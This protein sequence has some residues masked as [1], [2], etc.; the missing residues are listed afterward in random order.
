[1]FQEGESGA[2]SNA[3]EF[4]VLGVGEGSEDEVNL[5]E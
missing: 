1:M 5:G 3:K 4:L 2:D